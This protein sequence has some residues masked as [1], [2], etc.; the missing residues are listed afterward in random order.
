MKT[1]L[2][3]LLCCFLAITWLWFA[4]CEKDEDRTPKD[5]A[6][7][8]L[9]VND[10]GISKK[11]LVWEYQGTGD[12][13]GF[14]FDR[15]VNDND[16]E[17]GFKTCAPEARTW[18]DTSIIPVP[19]NTYQ[20]RLY[21]YYGSET[22]DQV[23][24]HFNSGFPPPSN[25][26][27]LITR[28]LKEAVISWE[29]NCHGEQGFKIDK[30]LNGE[31]WQESYA[32]IPANT[33]NYLDT[34]LIRSTNIEYRVYAFL[35]E[36]ESEK[37]KTKLIAEIPKPTTFQCKKVSI[38]KNE[39]TWDYQEG[40]VIDHFVIERKDASG[41][42]EIVDT[43]KN[44]TAIDSTFQLNNFYTYYI[45][46][47]IGESESEEVYTQV[48]THFE[49]PENL[50]IQRTDITKV[51][52]TWSYDL[53]GLDGFLIERSYDG[54]NWEEIDIAED[55]SF[56]DNNFELDQ[57]LQY[58][59]SAL[60]Q[61]QVSTSSEIEMSS[62]IPPPENL[63]KVRPQ[64]TVLELSWVYTLP[65]LQGFL[66]ERSYDNSTWED[67]GI[68]TE[69]NFVDNDFELNQHLYYRIS[70]YYDDFYSETVWIDF[71]STIP[72]PE[73]IQTK[74]LSFSEIQID[75]DESITNEDGFK[76]EKS[77][78][79]QTWTEIHIAP[80]N[81]TTFVDNDVNFI[82]CSSDF[83]HYRVATLFDNY[84][85]AF[86]QGKKSQSAIIDNRD[87]SIYNTLVIGDEHCWFMDNLRWL[88][89]V[90]PPEDEDIYTKYYYVVNYSGYDV[91]QAKSTWEYETFGVLYNWAAANDA[92]PEGWH[93]STRAEWY[94]LMSNTGGLNES[95]GNLKEKGTEHWNP[96]NTGATDDFSFKALPAGERYTQGYFRQTYTRA[97]FW[98]PNQANYSNWRY[99]FY[100]KNNSTAVYQND[101]FKTYGMSVRCVKDISK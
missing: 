41:I 30:R 10:L 4:G 47:T 77:L 27:V 16:W 71:V 9:R 73:N 17:T 96:P 62:F 46:A 36:Y 65:G 24:V 82:D 33:E 11:E 66:I 21:A 67:Y 18:T 95:G 99:N 32:V 31:T 84:Q 79:G 7:Q 53:P 42:T 13:E 74:T 61:G 56:T 94:V 68:T 28:P 100:I 88:P 98:T 35:E 23:N 22:S 1:Y 48:N 80:P 58:Q 87:G 97:K 5:W 70:G 43:T 39:L 76:L 85:S 63:T 75:W 20:Y 12:L 54:I 92:C 81:T 51:E 69:T 91:N 29:D 83:Y 45:S 25:A 57:L 52:L 14:K 34:N 44:L 40:Y 55:T 101:T 93:L 78:D 64:V 2:P 86:I 38:L 49:K 72:A 15:K 59:V 37:T 90:S 19:E 50:Q 89:S 8:K 26:T 6:P 60:V 3:F